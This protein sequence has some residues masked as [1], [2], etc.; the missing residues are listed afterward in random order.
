M[1]A[2][3][4]KIFDKKVNAYNQMYECSI[5]EYY[6][7]VKN[8]LGNN[9][10]QRRKVKS[11]SSIYSLLK[12]DLKQGCMIPPIV[13]AYVGENDSII[14]LNSEETKKHLLILDGLQ[15]SFAILDIVNDTQNLFDY[16]ESVLDLPIRIELYTNINRMGIL[17]RMLTLNTGQTRMSTRHQIEIIYSDYI[18]HS[19]LSNIQLIKEVGNDTPKSIGQ[20]KFRDV[21]EGFT[22]YIECD[23]LTLDRQDLLDQV[24]TLTKL[25]NETEGVELFT[26]YIDTYHKFVVKMNYFFPNKIEDICVSQFGSSVIEIF[27]KSQSLTGF[28]AAV[29]IM[30]EKGIINGFEIIQEYITKLYDENIK[31]GLETLLTNLDE[32]RR[33]AKK[34]GNDQRL[35]FHY[36]YRKLFDPEKD[37]FL[38]FSKS[39]IAAYKEYQRDVY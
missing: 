29:G 9:E 1:E 30:Q 36:L 19:P 4:T 16:N 37:S 23:Y 15:R 11:S 33:K 3:G 8:I 34:I 38:D 21:I 12:E 2:I 10:Y 22:S 32:I 7:L 18:T 26:K 20:Y 27:N 13:M 25:R 5:K 14:D 31:D 17:Y 28:G 39:T 6:E 35:Y 24:K